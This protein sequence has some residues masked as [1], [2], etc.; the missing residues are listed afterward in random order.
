VTYGKVS[1]L[2][3]SSLHLW[4]QPL[5]QFALNMQSQHVPSW[6]NIAELSGENMND[7]N[8]FP[9]ALETNNV[10][11]V[12]MALLLKANTAVNF[13]QFELAASLSVQ[14]SSYGGDT[15]RFHMPLHRISGIWLVHTMDCMQSQERGDILRKRASAKICYSN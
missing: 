12:L 2:L 15:L 9:Q 1:D 14:T 6:D 13:N 7:G 11:L 3:G 5:L 4:F 10:I 8:Y